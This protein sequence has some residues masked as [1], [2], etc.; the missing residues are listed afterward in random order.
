MH[1]QGGTEH[2]EEP[3]RQGSLITHTPPTADSECTPNVKLHVPPSSHPTE[4]RGRL[5]SLIAHAPLPHG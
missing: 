3:D 5:G 1:C 2:P 4:E